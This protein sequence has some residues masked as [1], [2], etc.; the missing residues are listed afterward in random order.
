MQKF[1]FLHIP[2]TA[3]S[4]F[5]GM[6]YRIHGRSNVFWYGMDIPQRR[7]VFDEEACRDYRYIGG[8]KNIAYYPPNLPAFWCSLL[9]DPVQRT[10]SL[11]SYYAK[12]EAAKDE[13]GKARRETELAKWV[14]KGLQPNSIVESLEQCPEFLHSVNNF[15]CRYLSYFDNSFEGVMSTIADKN[16]VIGLSENFNAFSHRLCEIFSWEQPETIYANTSVAS[17]N[18]SILEEPGAEKLIQELTTEDQKLYD[19]VS[20]STSPIYENALDSTSLRKSFSIDDQT[21]AVIAPDINW[22]EVHLSAPSRSELEPGKICLLDITVSNQSDS[23]LDPRAGRGLFFNVV[24]E[25][26]ETEKIECRMPRTL[27]AKK[28]PTGQIHRQKVRVFIS[29]DNYPQVATLVVILGSRGKSE[30]HNDFNRA[31]LRIQLRSPGLIQKLVFFCKET[32]MLTYFS[33]RKRWL[34]IKQRS[35]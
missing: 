14:A 28:I 1:I 30:A 32:S 23:D 15:Q 16:M 25:N 24:L 9:R 19:F 8:H 10:V 5:R 26:T 11:F 17:V 3:G 35:N 12:P 20:Q 27:L 29:P 2:K 22:H 21:S 6:L 31:Q 33:L 18:A 13:I 7:D 34:R 4:S